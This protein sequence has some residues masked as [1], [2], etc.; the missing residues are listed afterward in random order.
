[1]YSPTWLKAIVERDIPVLVGHA[2][3]TGL[4]TH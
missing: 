4:F 1:M 3:Q 2:C